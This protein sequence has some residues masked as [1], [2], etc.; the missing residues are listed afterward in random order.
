MK[1]RGRGLGV[2]ALVV[3]GALTLAACGGSDGG[4]GDAAASGGASGGTYSI[5]EQTPQDLTPSNCYDLY[6]ANIL[7]GVT[8]GLYTFKTEGSS[9]STI[10]TPLLKSV[11][12][13]DGARPT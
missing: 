11:T 13:P 1:I 10:G 3:A 6:C 7:Q 9:M 2:S 8:T 4:G 5:G 12:T